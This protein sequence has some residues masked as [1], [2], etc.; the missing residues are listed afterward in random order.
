MNVADFDDLKRLDP[1]IAA[2]I[3]Q[4][5]IE[6]KTITELLDH[7][8]ITG[9]PDLIGKLEQALDSAKN[10]YEILLHE[11]VNASTA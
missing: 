8:H 9:W 6:A 2:R 5:R 10:A 7:E 4:A 1:N 3:L 11:L